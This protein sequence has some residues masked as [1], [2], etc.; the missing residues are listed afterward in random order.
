M[1]YN[2]QLL[3]NLGAGTLGTSVSSSSGS[4]ANT[5]GSPLSYINPADIESITI[6]KDADATAIYGS[7]AANGAIL[8]TTKKGKQG[9]TKVDINIQNGWGKNIRRLQLMNTNEFLTM[10]HEAIRNDGM[11][12]TEWDYDINGIWDSSRNT[13][14][15]KELIG[16]TAHYTDA[17]LSL[18]GGTKL[19]QFLIGTGYHRETT[20]F[21]GDFSD[22]KGSFHFNINNVSNNQKLKIQLIGNYLVDNNQLPSADLTIT[23]L[24]LAPNAPSLYN[25]DGT[26]NWQ[27]NT[28]GSSTWSNPIANTY[29]SY[30]IKVANLVTNAI[31]SYEIISGLN[32]VTSFGYSNMQLDEFLKRPLFVIAPENRPNGTRI[33]IY[34]NSNINSWNIE[35]QAIYKRTIGSGKLEALVGTTIQQN[36]R[37]ASSFLGLGYNSDNVMKDISAASQI[38]IFNPAILSVYKYNALFGRINYNFQDKYILNITARRDGS[39]RF[40]ANNQFHNFG[41]IGAAWVFSQESFI[42]NGIPILSFGKFRASYGTTGND[43]IGDYQFLNLYSPTSTVEVPYQGATGILP[44]GLPNPYLQWERTKKLSLGLDLGFIKDRVLVEINYSKN[45]SSNQLLSYKLPISTGFFG[46]NKNF[47]ATVQNTSWEFSLSSSNVRSQQFKWESIINL[48]V[49]KN[50]LISF[51]NLASSSYASGLIIGQPITIQKVY[52]FGGVNPNTGIYQF[53]DSH[54]NLTTTPD[55][56]T[57][58]TVIINTSPKFYGGI[59]NKFQY[60]NIQLE[61]LLYFVKQIGQNYYFGNADNAAFNKNQ[62][63]YLINRWQ[64]PGDISSIQRYNSDYSLIDPYFNVIQSDAAFSD[65]SY[66]R[67]KN[68]ALSYVIPKQWIKKPCTVYVHG[69]NVFTV[70]NY[71]GLD[72]ENLTVNSLPPLRTV[73]LGIR[74]AL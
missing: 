6:L 43:Q 54:G 29:Q 7:R 68:I 2:S 57:D 37:S 12:V 55:G 49:P 45:R 56:S 10:R 14:W 50:K 19:T 36:K 15:Q 71:K 8:I 41:A 72:P 48:T 34:E 40:G 4:P 53:V 16:R 17:Q 33:A 39:S 25:S 42:Q 60:G 32:L 73:T 65:A 31:V 52:H 61:F 26:L 24:Q 35:P 23:A 28:A 51:P 1:P 11:S 59:T 63:D 21:P 66:I 20:V 58:N 67:L 70:T 47:P 38:R 5:S 3:P 27:P 22:K 64:K 13:N 44:N 74:V 9:E 62:P 18:S 69:Q 46:I 30:Q